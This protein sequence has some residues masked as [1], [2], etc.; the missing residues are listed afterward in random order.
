LDIARWDRLQDRAKGLFMGLPQR[1]PI[2]ASRL[3]LNRLDEAENSLGPI[4]EVQEPFCSLLSIVQEDM[5][6]K[7][8]MAGFTELGRCKRAV[9][10]TSRVALRE[11]ED[12]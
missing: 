5:L 3:D 6:E 10:Q 8:S 4:Q 2:K 7:H 9:R 1:P 11:I 12:D